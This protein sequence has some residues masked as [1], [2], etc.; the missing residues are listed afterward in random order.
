MKADL[1]ESQF[2]TSEDPVE[3]VTVDVTPGPAEVV[4]AVRMAF[5]L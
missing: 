2:R 3:V 4:Q 1:L 5:G